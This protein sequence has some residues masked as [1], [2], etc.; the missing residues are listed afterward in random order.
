MSN[1]SK[2]SNDFIS[3][4]CAYTRQRQGLNQKQTQKPVQSQGQKQTQKPVQSQGQKQSQIS[5]QRPGQKQVQKQ[6]QRP[7][8]SKENELSDAE[9]KELYKESYNEFKQVDKKYSETNVIQDNQINAENFTRLMNK[10]NKVGSAY[11]MTKILQNI[12]NEFNAYKKTLGGVAKDLSNDNDSLKKM[13]EEK[14]RVITN[15]DKKIIEL[16]NIIKFLLKTMAG[17]SN[18]V[19]IKIDPNSYSSFNDILMLFKEPSNIKGSV[20]QILSTLIQYTSKINTADC[21]NSVIS[22][23]QDVDELKNSDFADTFEKCDNLLKNKIDEETGEFNPDGGPYDEFGNPIDQLHYMIL[24]LY[25]HLY[26]FEGAASGARSELHSL[27]ARLR[28]FINRDISDNFTNLNIYIEQFISIFNSIKENYHIMKRLLVTATKER[29]VL[30]QK[31][32]SNDKALF[33]EIS[34]YLHDTMDDYQPIIEIINRSLD[35][36]RDEVSL[37]EAIREKMKSFSVSIYNAN[38]T[39]NTILP[40]TPTYIT[41]PRLITSLNNSLTTKE[42]VDAIVFSKLSLDIINDFEYAM[43]MYDRCTSPNTSVQ[44][45]SEDID[46]KTLEDMY[47]DCMESFCDENKRKYIYGLSKEVVNIMTKYIN[48]SAKPSPGKFVGL[49]ILAKNREA[50]TKVFNKDP[51]TSYECAIDSAITQDLPS[52]LSTFLASHMNFIKCISSDFSQCKVKNQAAITLSMGI[53]L[54]VSALDHP[55]LSKD[56]ST[57]YLS[58]EECGEN[59]SKYMMQRGSNNTVINTYINNYFTAIK[60]IEANEVSIEASAVAINNINS[61]ITNISNNTIHVDNISLNNIT[62]S[63]TNETIPLVELFI[64]VYGENVEFTKDEKFVTHNDPM[65][66]LNYIKNTNDFKAYRDDI[67]NALLAVEAKLKSQS[68]Q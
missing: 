11:I 13:V 23:E 54:Y 8:Q 10:T 49:M 41:H 27:Y 66:L 2:D 26:P 59:I 62:I 65:K 9:L 12:T 25:N 5:V 38:I 34:K 53:I 45:L 20:D 51:F 68:H 15:Q 33:E 4:Y 39:D 56:S 18:E 31:A 67:K 35:T 50:A 6:T 58:Y 30:I 40:T 63:L 37:P 17:D 3:Q 57:H 44:V 19:N 14:N 24:Q 28:P 21:S 7:N 46:E 48:D 52:S 60:K 32:G 16:N 47:N 22:L 29:T 42:R 43:S 61:N 55:I 64:R 36:I 1:L